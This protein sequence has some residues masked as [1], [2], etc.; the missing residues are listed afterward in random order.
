VRRHGSIYTLRTGGAPEPLPG[1]APRSSS[2]S[3]KGRRFF[4]DVHRL[5]AAA[6]Q[7][8]SV[9]ARRNLCNDGA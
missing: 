9:F 5:R 2:E 4:P 3:V 1:G 7:D 6:A 8:F